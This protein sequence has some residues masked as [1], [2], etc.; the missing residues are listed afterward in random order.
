MQTDIVRNDEVRESSAML[1]PE[2]LRRPAVAL[3][4]ICVGTTMALGGRYAGE[5]EARWFD[6]AV[7]ARVRAALGGHTWLQDLIWL[8]HPVVVAIMTAMLCLY[9]LHQRRWRAL[10]MVVLA[11]GSA[12]IATE[13][14]LKPFFHRTFFG[15][16]A[17]PSGH[18]TGAFVIAA[19]IAVLL[20]NPPRP[21]IR[22]DVRALLGFSA[23]A[24]AGVV[25]I[26]VLAANNHYATDLVGGAAV[27]TAA[28]LGAGLVVD[29]LAA[30]LSGIRP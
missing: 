21:R 17:F 1:L 4:L 2:P 20:V 25:C 16:L 9:C 6:A 29:G 27:A 30:R 5:S 12:C 15:G 23:L 28:A 10:V 8:G 11:V 26:A 22:A 13:L 7:G 3:L 19:V 18:A 14:V 24:T